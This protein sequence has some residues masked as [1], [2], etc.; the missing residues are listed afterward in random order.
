MQKMTSSRRGRLVVSLLIVVHFTAIALTYATNW[1]RSQFQD[2]VLGWLQPYLILGCWDQE[3][4][5]VEWVSDQN[6]SNIARVSIQTD[7][8]S[9]KWIH[10]LESQTVGRRSLTMDHAK[11]D[12]LLD[13]ML[14]LT[15]NENDENIE[16][17]LTIFKSIVLHIESTNRTT[18]PNEFV[19]SIRLEH[20]LDNA[21]V[22]ATV[23]RFED[24]EIGLIPKIESFRTVRAKNTE[25]TP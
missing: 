16:G 24:G 1:R 25:T 7:A 4:L 20:P 6:K 11:T 2:Q 21:L 5:P 17:I 3:M 8:D 10:V 23:A 15:E 18:S 12:R 13:L 14:K 22:E 9:T 19:A